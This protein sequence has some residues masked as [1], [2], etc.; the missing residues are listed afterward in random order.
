MITVKGTVLAFAEGRK[1][2]ADDHGPHD[3]VMRRSLDGCKTWAPMQVVVH[4]GDNALNNPTAVI[5]RDMI[6]HVEANDLATIIRAAARFRQP[7]VNTSHTIED[8][9]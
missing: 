9:V 8:A 3:I 4:D 2:S 1:E 6:D 5:D 7:A